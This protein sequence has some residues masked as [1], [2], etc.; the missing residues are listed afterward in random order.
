MKVLI[1]VPDLRRPGGVANYF[2]ALALDKFDG[3]T[4]F[5]IHGR[6]KN[7]ASKFKRLLTR[8][9]EFFIAIR[10]CD[11]VHLNPSLDFKSYYRDMVFALLTWL[12]GKR[13]IVFWRGWEDGFEDSIRRSRLKIFLFRNTYGKA[14]VFIVLG[15]CFEDKLKGLGVAE[16][17]RI[18]KETTVADAPHINEFNIAAKGLKGGPIKLLFLS[19]L[20]KDK[21]IYVAIDTLRLLVSSGINAVLL[22]A[23][24]GAEAQMAQTYCS[25]RRIKGV[26]FCGHIGGL[27]KH[28]ALSDADIFL[29]PSS[30]GEGLPNSVLEAMLYGLPVI[31][32][33][34]A[35]IPDVVS[36]GVNGFLTESREPEIFAE[37]ISRLVRDKNLYQRMSMSNHTT[38]LER[39]TT[40][41]VRTRLFEIYTE[42][43]SKRP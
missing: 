33:K 15:S 4:Y 2:N 27:E 41:K 3:V 26:T 6:D 20:E 17:K 43:F 22:V 10:D 23:G 13:L 37:L 5:C 19:R 8:Y 32:R 9:F 11:I 29:L 42:A 14:D 1:N 24:E 34:L 7:P 12:S 18:F 39:F 40:D 30:Y 36:D 38:A 35:G 16:G 25:D 28:R 31:T 21:G